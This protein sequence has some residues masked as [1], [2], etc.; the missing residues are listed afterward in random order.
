MQRKYKYATISMLLI[1]TVLSVVSGLKII[2]MSDNNIEEEYQYVDVPALSTD[3]P[4]TSTSMKITKPYSN[5]NVAIAID[6]YDKDSDNQE[7]SIIVTDKTYMPNV[8]ILYSN[9]EIFDILCILDGTVSEIGKNDL[10]G[11]YVKI[12]HSNN[13]VSLYQIIDDIK[14]KKGDYVKQGD[15][16][17]TSSTSTLNEGNL[18]LFELLID[19]Q[20][21]NPEKYYNKDIKEI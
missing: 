10:I 21:V 11:N 17:G 7:K 5:K 19:D 4:V 3:Q 18:L 14:V 8:G 16:I 2:R 12:T 15:K 9:K 1:I 13:I 20:N 6:Y